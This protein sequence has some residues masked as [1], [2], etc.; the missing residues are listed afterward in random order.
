MSSH[1]LGHYLLE[2]GVADSGQIEE[3]AAFQASSNRRLGD[4]AVEAGLLSPAQVE[5]LL[6]LQRETDMSFGELAVA[7]GWVPRRE[8]HTLLFRQR[9]RQFH[10]GEAL[11]TLG[12]ITPEQF[13]N[14][15]EAYAALKR[16]RAQE[17]EELYRST[18][19]PDAVSG[20][21][22][23]LERAFLRFAR[24]PLKAQGLMPG[25]ELESYP[26]SR[27]AS[28]PLGGG[29]ELAYTLRLGPEMIRV[30]GQAAGDRTGQ[31]EEADVAVRNLMDMICLY[32]RA[33]AKQGRLTPPPREFAG[34]AVP[35]D[36]GHSAIILKLACP[37]A[38]AGLLIRAVQAVQ[39]TEEP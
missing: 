38:S 39:A 34:R 26:L 7:R 10:L 22:S 36:G 21:V 18:G 6:V 5:E 33:C 29:R 28:V 27:D 19:L 15:L 20:L 2:H 8:M 23:A 17:L 25:E 35:A 16:G 13:S 3:A 31:C 37:K 4:L 24:C 14:C 9:V 32:P 12:H 1:C 30:L 11:L